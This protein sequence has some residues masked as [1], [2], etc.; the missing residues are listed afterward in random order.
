MN[1][2]R[3][4]ELFFFV[5]SLFLLSPEYIIIRLYSRVMRSEMYF[6]PSICDGSANDPHRGPAAQVFPPS[7]PN[8]YRAAANR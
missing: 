8:S 5:L 2:K 3:F 4:P 6:I 1:A 7:P